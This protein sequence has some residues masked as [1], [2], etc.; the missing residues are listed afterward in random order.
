MI[1]ELSL[2]YS[3]VNTAVSLKSSFS[4]L[5]V[6]SLPITGILYEVSHVGMMEDLGISSLMVPFVSKWSHRASV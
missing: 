5:Y 1:L 3:V 2:S 6:H 4:P